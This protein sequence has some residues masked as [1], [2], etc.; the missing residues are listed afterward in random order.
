MVILDISA[1]SWTGRVRSQN[2][3]MILVDHQFIREDSYR[4][5][6]VLGGEDRMLIAVADGM[7]GHNRGDAASSDTLHN[8]HYYF[9]DIPSTLSAE[10]YNKAIVEWLDSINNY[11][12]SKGRAD[13]QF[14]GMGTTLVGL[15]YYN[16]DFYSMN[17]G[18]SRLYRFYNHQLVQLTTDH[19]LNDKTSS[20]KRSNVLTNCIGGG[21][22]SSF[23]DQARITDDMMQ[24]DVFLLCTDGL[25]DMLPDETITGLLEQ[26]ADADAL[27]HA[28]IEAGGNDNVSCCVITIK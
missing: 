23:I 1:A 3:D 19:S 26:K 4:T 24:Y 9:Y 8:L 28:A 27:C 6:V 17:C 22:S 2:E 14:K 12:A 10:E 18:D 5:Q 11:V 13:E 20:G 25:T 21:S 16:R 15:T 7:G